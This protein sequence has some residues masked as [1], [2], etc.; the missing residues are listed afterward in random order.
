VKSIR[1]QV[2]D[3]DTSAAIQNAFVSTHV[4]TEVYTTDAEGKF[5]IQKIGVETNTLIMKV[6]ADNYKTLSQ[7]FEFT[8]QNLNALI[9]LPKESTP[10]TVTPLPDNA[11]SVLCIFASSVYGG[12]KL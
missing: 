4:A 3:Y 9:Y 7:S 11:P 5:K 10:T 2:T 1:G 6:V 8:C 12:C